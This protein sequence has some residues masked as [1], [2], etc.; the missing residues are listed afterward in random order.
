MAR[1]LAAGVVFAPGLVPVTI[2]VV[3][4]GE[5]I[6]EAAESTPAWR[7]V[8]AALVVTIE[9][10]EEVIEHRENPFARGRACKNPGP[11]LMDVSQGLTGEM[12]LAAS[13]G[14]SVTRIDERCSAFR[15]AEVGYSPC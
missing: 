12:T 1:A 2:V 15:N 10:I 6:E 14:V 4:G 13:S 7:A 5:T 8:A 11:I 9:D 3:F